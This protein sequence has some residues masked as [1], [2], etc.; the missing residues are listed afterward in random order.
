MEESDHLDELLTCRLDTGVK[1]TEPCTI[2]IFGASGDLTARKLIPALYHL[3]V[4]MQLPDPIRIIG[5]VRREKK[6][7]QWHEEL[8]SALEQY[9][10]TKQVHPE[11][12]SAFTSNVHYCEGDYADP[13]A[14][15]R[16]K[17]LLASFGKEPL[18]RN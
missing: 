18:R 7:A 8:K 2:I 10:R 14:Y 13:A 1:A 5:F 4:A 12:W 9:S 17:Q 3:F 16:L 6:T 11:V 15:E